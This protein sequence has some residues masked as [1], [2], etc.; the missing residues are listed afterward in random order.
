MSEFN[1]K[2]DLFAFLSEDKKEVDLPVDKDILEDVVPE[3]DQVEEE[4]VVIP[5]E[6]KETTVVESVENNVVGTT[7]K[8]PKPAKT[9][10]SKAVEV[11]G[12]KDKV[13]IYS[14]KNV[15][16][17]SVGT[18]YRGFNIVTPEV[19]E[20]WLERNHI[21]MATPEEVAKEFGL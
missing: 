10:K 15:T 5:E 9:N 20:K 14:S 18:V 4:V 21:R 11:P 1:N 16:W 6:V 8:T 19:A 2:E 12:R 17:S 7:T 3:L 13:A